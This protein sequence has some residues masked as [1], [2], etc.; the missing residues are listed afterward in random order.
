[1]GTSPFWEAGADM[2]INEDQFWL[3]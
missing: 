1:M 3:L 2:R